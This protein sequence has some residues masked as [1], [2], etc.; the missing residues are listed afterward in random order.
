[1]KLAPQNFTIIVNWKKQGFSC[2]R[3]CSYCNWRDSPFLPHGAQDTG[4]ISAFIRQC[5]KSF[6]T[7]SGGADP[8]YQFE[9][10]HGHLL[11]MIQTIKAHG[12]KVRV[13]TRE[14]E[15]LAK[16]RGIVDQ[17]SISLDSDVLEKLGDYRLEWKGLDIEFSLV[18]PPLSTA[19]LVPLMPQYSALHRRLGRRLALRENFNGIHGIDFSLLSTGHRGIVFVPKSLCL[20]SRYLTTGDHAGHEILLDNAQL[21]SYLMHEPHV[22]I[23]GGAVR[24]LLC[25]VHT[26]FTDIDLIATDAAVMEKLHGRFGYTFREVSAAQSPHPRY[27]VGKPNR[28]GKQTHLVLLKS[29]EEALRY[30]RSAQYDIDRVSYSAG[31]LYFDERIGEQAIRHAINTKQATAVGGSRDFRLFSSNRPLVEQRHKVKLLRKGFTI[32][33]SRSLHHAASDNLHSPPSHGDRQSDQF[34]GLL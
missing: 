18:L 31:R 34:A 3:A 1:M 9:E 8:L 14:I 33:E 19:D 4:A 29:A 20:S 26:E 11:S 22:H 27:F 32:H 7:I 2:A 13:L 12:F 6:I 10:N 25:P 5:R 16:L 30:V 21:F 28:A 24:H 15:H 23:F 17:F